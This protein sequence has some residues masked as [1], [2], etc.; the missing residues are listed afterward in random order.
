[1]VYRRYFEAAVSRLKDERR[2]RVFAH[3]ERDVE[4]FPLA[5]WHRDHSRKPQVA[6][7]DVW[8]LLAKPQETPQA[9]AERSS[10]MESLREAIR[11]LPPDRQLLLVLKYGDEKSNLEIG[12]VLG[13]SEG[14]VKSLFHRTLADLRAEM[15]RRGHGSQ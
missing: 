4:A 11:H 8:A 10:E 5:N 7:E 3:L 6:L 13:K 1:M 15:L 14:A 12:R 9:L 2:Y